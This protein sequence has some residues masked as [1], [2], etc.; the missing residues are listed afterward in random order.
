MSAS[1]SLSGHRVMQI[2]CDPKADSTINLTNG[3]AVPSVLEAL[4]VYG[5]GLQA[6]HFLRKGSCGCWCVESGGPKPGSGC[7]GRGII[8]AFETLQRLSVYEMVEPDIV[9]YDV[10]GDVVCGGFSMPIRQGYADEVVIVSS[11]EKMSLFAAKNIAEA[12]RSFGSEGSAALRGIIANQKG[13]T[14]EQEAIAGLS[15]ELDIPVLAWIPR[16]P[17]V[18]EAE[19]LCTT[20]T[21]LY[22]QS[23]IASIYSELALRLL[24]E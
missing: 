18:Q 3:E 5:S 6:E 17:S 13:F 14:G 12:V 21:E 9:F 7:A 23:G 22:P 2:G 19:N 1:L 15:R 11:G 24:G 4:R 20:V 10:L 16:D 8:T